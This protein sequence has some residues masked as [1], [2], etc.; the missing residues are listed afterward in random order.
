MINAR[1]LLQQSLQFGLTLKDDARALRLEKRQAADK[2]EGVSQ[3]LLPVHEHGFAVNGQAAVPARAGRLPLRA[4]GAIKAPLILR[5]PQGEVAHA[6]PQV[7]PIEMH[8]GLIGLEPER[9]IYEPE[10]LLWAALCAPAA[11]QVIQ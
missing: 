5:P 9:P 1:V 6:E 11:R 3:A 8:L 10:R 2:L 7:R 4:E